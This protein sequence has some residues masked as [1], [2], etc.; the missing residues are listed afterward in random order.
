MTANWDTGRFAPKSN[1]DA[2]KWATGSEPPIDI[3]M[4]GLPGERFPEQ[5]SRLK[6]I[7]L[8]AEERDDDTCARNET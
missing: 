6:S 7:Y 2:V 5:R 8:H 4:P 3:D 1:P